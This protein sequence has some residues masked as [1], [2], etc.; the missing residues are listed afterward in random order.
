[1]DFKKIFHSAL[2]KAKIFKIAPNAVRAVGEKVIKLQAVTGI[3]NFLSKHNKNMQEERFASKEYFISEKEKVEENISLL[4]DEMSK[5]T[6]RTIIEYR[7]TCSNRAVRSVAQSPKMHYLDPIINLAQKEAFVD[8]GGFFAETTTAISKALAKKFKNKKTDFSSLVIEPDDFN[9]N[10]CLK[11]MAKQKLNA[12]CENCAVVSNN[13][14]VNF[15]GGI[16][17]SCRVVSDGSETVEAATIDFLC[18]KHSFEPTYIK[19][20]I[21]GSEADALIGS[22]NVIEKFKPR[23]AV[24]IYHS[25]EDMVELI[26]YIHQKYPFYNFYVRHYSGFFAETILYC[27]PQ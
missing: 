24:S 13:G 3:Y 27:I 11:N 19:Y 10:V 26:R 2:K 20:D 25:N 16:F 15:N 12:F 18:Q 23:L 4:A 14:T 7:C 21:E 22:H 8:A 1:M 9:Y 5:K 6:Y 17:G